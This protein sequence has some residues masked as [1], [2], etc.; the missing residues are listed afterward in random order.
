MYWP[1]D[2]LGVTRLERFTPNDPIQEIKGPVL[3]NTCTKI[4]CSC[5]GSLDEGVSPKYAL[6]KWSLAWSV[7]PQLQDLS[8]AEQLLVSRV[9]RI[10]ALSRCHLVCTDESDV[11][12]L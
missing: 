11:Y 6:A 4:C 1:R 12:C 8:Y 10:S 7:P 3:D 9:R 2:G 5:K